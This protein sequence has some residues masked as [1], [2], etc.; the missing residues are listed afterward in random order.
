MQVIYITNPSKVNLRIDNILIADV[1]VW[2]INFFLV[3]QLDS[4]VISVAVAGWRGTV[5]WVVSLQGGMRREIDKGSRW[6]GHP[7]F[8]PGGV[9]IRK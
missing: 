9:P 8:L 4:S 3:A 6:D 7:D 2:P 1:S 5:K